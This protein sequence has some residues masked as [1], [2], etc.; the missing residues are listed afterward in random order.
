MI[1]INDAGSVDIEAS[2]RNT[3]GKSIMFNCAQAEVM[4]VVQICV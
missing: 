4:Q 3:T 1:G 2:S